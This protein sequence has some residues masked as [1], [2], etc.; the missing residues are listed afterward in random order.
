MYSAVS[1]VT[2]KDNAKLAYEYSL[3][4]ALQ[5]ADDLVKANGA[6]KRSTAFVRQRRGARLGWHVRWRA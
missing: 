1:A 2:G 5:C 6:L 4:A 3:V